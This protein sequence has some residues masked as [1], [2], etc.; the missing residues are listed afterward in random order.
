M[1]TRRAQVAVAA[2]FVVN[3]VCFGAWVARIPAVR[4][5]LDLTAAT[6]GLL[7]LCPGLGS[8]VGLPT[9]GWFVA[10]IGPARGVFAGAVGAGAG[11]LC[12]CA[13][14]WTGTV[15][16][17]AVGLGLYGLAVSYWDVSIN[18]AGARLEH[19]TGRVLLPRM[20]A[21][22]SLGSAAGAGLGAA[23][24]AVGV[25]A[26]TQFLVT[27]PLVAGSVALVT[28]SFPPP[29]PRPDGPSTLRL[30][31]A[32]REP[33][34]LAI[35]TLVL[36]FAFTEGVA[37]DWLA[38][39]LTEGHHATEAV[40][41]L[42]YAVFSAALAGGRLAGGP[43]LARTGRVF[44]LRAMAVAG[45]GGVLAVVYAGTLP[46]ALAGA[47]LW[48]FGTALGFPVGMS[49][50]GD[51]PVRAAVRVSVVSSIG[52]AAFFAGPPLV[53]FLAD[54]VGVLPALSVVLVALAVAV[55]LAPATRPAPPVPRQR[56]GDPHSGGR[57]PA[58]RNARS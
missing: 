32:W 36:A 35:G 10:R 14:L 33:R 29:Q 15:A 22:L 24:T 51:D 50:A 44:A 26:A 7:L 16:P 38:L 58:A 9:A 6:L 8:M 27:A 34:T 46:I 43:L 20:H 21:G 30:R 23:V 53:G 57:R 4:D 49:A 18:V 40:G 41:A 48:G 17:A 55:L 3:G 2:A 1:T 47:A 5:D 52:Y 31:R 42:G 12:V 39:A 13:G 11:L 19:L 54:H 56:P 28:R 37:N 25:T 45:A